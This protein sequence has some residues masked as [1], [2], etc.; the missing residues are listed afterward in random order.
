MIAVVAAASISGYGASSLM[1]EPW[2]WEESDVL[3]LIRDQEQESLILDYKSSDALQK[4]DGKKNELSK[5]VSAFANSAG[6]IL[7]YGAEE[8][9]HIPVRIDAGCDPNE[10]SK[11]WLEQVINSRIQRRIDGIV[12][13]QIS[14]SGAN[15]GR[16]IYVVLVPSSLQAPH[17][18]S[19]NKFYKRF[20]FQSVP[21]EEYEVRDASRRSESPDLNISI[22]IPTMTRKNHWFGG[23]ARFSTN[24]QIEF[25]VGND[26]GVPAENC[27]LAVFWDRRLILQRVS[28]KKNELVSV[29]LANEIRFDSHVVPVFS[30]S[31]HW[32]P[33][34]RPLIW[35]GI[36]LHLTTL[37]MN[38][39]NPSGPYYLFWE[40]RAPYMERKTGAF[41]LNFIENRYELSKLSVNWR[42]RSKDV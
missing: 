14:L 18:A 39:S 38:I 37:P 41:V 33:I 21:M 2:Q 6:G 7:I 40:A 11:E 19:D 17:M 1:K 35:E 28:V 27:F 5:D 4:T 31:L 3:N 36:R 22:E 16:V 10:I 42:R 15:H 24:F 8:N 9:G 23:N 29:A 34:E 32:R 12:I 30:Y 13:N 20:N 25:S 26:S